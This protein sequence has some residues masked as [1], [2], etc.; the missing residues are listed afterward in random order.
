M[1]PATWRPPRAER[2]SLRPAGQP[3]RGALR[4]LEVVARRALAHHPEE[5]APHFLD[6]SR[7]LRRHVTPFTGIRLEVVEEAPAVV[8]AH[9]ERPALVADEREVAVAAVGERPPLCR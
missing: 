2:L 6:A 1:A 3:A 8:V 5:P 7:V 4:P 9:H